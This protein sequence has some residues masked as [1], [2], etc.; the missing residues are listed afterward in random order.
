MK[1]SMALTMFLITLALLVMLVIIDLIL[2]YFGVFC[3]FFILLFFALLFIAVQWFIA[4]W[5]VKRSAGIDDAAVSRAQGNRFLMDTVKGMVGKAGIPMPKVAI[6]KSLEP[7]AFVFGTAKDDTWLVVHQGLLEHLNKDE[8]EG[9]LAHEIGHLKHGDCIVMTIA[10]AIPL[11]MYIMARFGFSALRGGRMAR[12]KNAGKVL[13]V[14]V[15]VAI[16]SYLV[17]LVTQMMVLYL[18]RS[19]EYYADEYSA[20]IT[21]APYKL[22]SALVKITTG[23]SL[24]TDKER[25]SGLRAFYVGDPVKARDDTVLFKE[26]MSEYDLD[27]DGTIDEHELEVATRKEKNPWRSVNEL[28]S[29]HPN[30][31]KRILTL[32]KIELEMDTLVV[33]PEPD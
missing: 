1:A 10:S 18:S 7:N 22:S 9:V 25:P 17:Y 2:L 13:L 6:L 20:R 11:M 27:G 28:F 14:I 4:P 21:G 15:L 16:V 23:L 26:R 3:N 8:I 29:T 19:R 5:M 24:K 31:Y 32:R 30:M 12:G 33:G